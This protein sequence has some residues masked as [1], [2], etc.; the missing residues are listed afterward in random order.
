MAKSKDAID[1]FM[2]VAAMRYLQKQQYKYRLKKFRNE[3][4]AGEADKRIEDITE[5]LKTVMKIVDDKIE[6]GLDFLTDE[7]V[8]EADLD[9]V[10]RWSVKDAI[11]MHAWKVEQGYIQREE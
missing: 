8:D 4:P 1:F 11:K 5:R 6:Y 2:K 7:M 9:D 10:V 3:M